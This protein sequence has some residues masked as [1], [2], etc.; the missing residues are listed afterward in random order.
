M[1]ISHTYIPTTYFKTPAKGE[2]GER[3]I[4][5]NVKMTKNTDLQL[6]WHK[7]LHST[8]TYTHTHTAQYKRL[9]VGL[10][11]TD[12]WSSSTQGTTDNYHHSLWL[13][14]PARASGSK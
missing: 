10:P 8:H 7:I 14:P 12:K 13:C 3:L 6:I 11:N 2:M 4:F 9:K 1:L 5:Q